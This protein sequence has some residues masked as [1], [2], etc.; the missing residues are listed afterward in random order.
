MWQLLL[1]S[2]SVWNCDHPFPH[3]QNFTVQKPGVKSGRNGKITRNVDVIPS[4][5]AELR[6]IYIYIYVIFSGGYSYFT[7]FLGCILGTFFPKIEQRRQVYSL[8]LFQ[9]ISYFVQRKHIYTWQI[10]S[11]LHPQKLT[12][13][14]KKKTHQFEDESPIKNCDVPASHVSWL[15]GSI[16][17]TFSVILASPSY[18][19]GLRKPPFGNRVM[20]CSDIW[21]ALPRACQDTLCIGPDGYDVIGSRDG[22]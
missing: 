13:H 11:G 6:L 3:Q 21:W 5:G 12:W 18:F 15:E 8:H 19:G 7:E 10:K 22:W 14:W 9:H 17:R 16:G 4:G 2:S 1:I 20:S